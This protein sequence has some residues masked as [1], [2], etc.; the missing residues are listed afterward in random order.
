MLLVQE[1]LKETYGHD[2]NVSV[3]KIVE[4]EGAKDSKEGLT[5]S[6]L[7]PAHQLWLH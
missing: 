2:L 3:T 5:L 7:H 1:L 4:L 6:S